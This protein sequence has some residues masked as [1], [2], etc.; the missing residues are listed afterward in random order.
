VT[1]SVKLVSTCF[2]APPMTPPLP[3]VFIPFVFSLGTL[4]SARACLNLN[5]V[6][7]SSYRRYTCISVS[8]CALPSVVAFCFAFQTRYLGSYTTCYNVPQSEYRNCSPLKIV[9]PFDTFH[10]TSLPR[11]LA[12]ALSRQA[13]LLAPGTS[14]LPYFLPSRSPR[15]E[16]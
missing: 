6:L 10:S 1:C 15:P 3:F 7:I 5:L 9:P 2:A 13:P 16:T 4:P 12:P 8:P 11:S 14:F